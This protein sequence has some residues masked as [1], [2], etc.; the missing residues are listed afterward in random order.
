MQGPMISPLLGR[1]KLRRSLIERLGNRELLGELRCLPSPEQIPR[2]NFASNDYL[3]LGKRKVLGVPI[4]STGSRLLTGNH[5]SIISIEKEM[6]DFFQTESA[7][8]FASGFE[9]NVG[10]M[11]SL[12]QEKD[13][14]LF[15]EYVHASLREGIRLSKAK[16]LPFRHND[17]EHLERRLLAQESNVFVVVES[18]Y[19]MDGDL[20]P[21]RDIV[22]LCDQWGAILIVDEAHGTGLYG[23]HG[24]GRVI[25][26]GLGNRIPLRVHTFGKSLGLQGGCVVGDEDVKVFLSN[27]CKEFIY[28]TAPSPLLCE[29]LKEQLQTMAEDHRGRQKLRDSVG[30]FKRQ[31]LAMGLDRYYDFPRILLENFSPIIPLYLKPQEEAPNK[32]NLKDL[33]LFLKRRGILALPI[34]SPTVPRGKERLR[35]SFSAM[36]TEPDDGRGAIKWLLQSL[37]DFAS[38]EV[39]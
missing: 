38:G 11:S 28:T 15:D 2:F 37:E 1:E 33:S 36:D 19:S 3:G 6:A 39:Q 14:I 13:V 7:L 23:P 32:Q 34:L 29:L 25:E 22:D 12:P 27:F 21:L 9:A 24:E 26:E 20:A 5:H 4:S 18:V 17:L 16:G 8:M 10:I 30:F 31:F 35:L